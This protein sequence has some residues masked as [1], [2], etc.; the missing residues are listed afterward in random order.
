MAFVDAGRENWKFGMNFLEMQAWIA[1]VFL[2]LTISCAG[3][4]LNWLR[5]IRKQL[6][7]L[8]SRA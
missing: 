6:T 4:L 2:K 5:Q 7:E 8:G 1:W 3:L